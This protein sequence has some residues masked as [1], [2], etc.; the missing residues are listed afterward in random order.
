MKIINEIERAFAALSD[1]FYGSI[2]ISY[3]NGEPT[4]VKTTST[5]PLRKNR[6]NDKTI[7]QNQLHQRT[8]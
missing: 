6:N 8:S 1:D 4:I 7:Q 2:E 3:Q 5:R